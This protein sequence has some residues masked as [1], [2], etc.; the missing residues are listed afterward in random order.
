M[1]YIYFH[2]NTG[3]PMIVE[4]CFGN[5][6]DEFFNR[7]AFTIKP[8]ERHLVHNEKKDVC[9]WRLHTSF[10]FYDKENIKVW[11]DRGLNYVTNIGRFR[12][13][14]YA[15]GNYSWLE[16]DV[17]DLFEVEYSEIVAYGVKGQITLSEKMKH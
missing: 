17:E 13:K 4:T 14:P 1:A 8:H 3:L 7:K 5:N 15:S 9:E 10:D 11:T 16:V 6:F 12:N 2:N